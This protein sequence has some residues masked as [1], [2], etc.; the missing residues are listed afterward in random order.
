MQW[1]IT[2]ETILVSLIC[3]GISA[4][5][6]KRKARSPYRWFFVGFLF[7]IFGTFAAYFAPFKRRKVI[8]L[9]KE[10][11]PLPSIQGP[12]DK[13]WYYLD[14]TQTQQGPM[15]LN[16]LTKAFRE[17]KISLTTFVWNEELTEWKALK[18]FLT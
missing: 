4:Y 12:S 5:F 18:E 8:I 11:V 6:A 14:S 2:L 15:S 1:P 9:P 13:H 10:E 17:G 16:A 3:G 7:G